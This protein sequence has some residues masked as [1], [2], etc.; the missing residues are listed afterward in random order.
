MYVM[1]LLATTKPDIVAAAAAAVPTT[2]RMRDHPAAEVEE[3]KNA[4]VT[5]HAGI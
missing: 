5:T 1:V 4:I 2:S 3:S